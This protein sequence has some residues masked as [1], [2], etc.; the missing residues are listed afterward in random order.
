MTTTT[1]TDM[2]TLLSDVRNF[3]EER[4]IP[5]EPKLRTD[6]LAAISSGIES[7]REVAKE[8]GW[9]CPQMNAEHG[10]MGLSLHDFG[11]LSEVLGRSPLGHLA[12]NCQAPDAGNMEILADHASEAQ[13]DAFLDPLTAGEVRS[14]FAMTE[15]E[16]AGSNPKQ[17][18]TTAE[19]VSDENGEAYVLNGHKWFTTGADGADFTIVM[20]VTNPDA[21]NP[22]QRA[23]MIIVPMDAEGLEHVRKIPIMGE[24]GEGWLS[25]SELR[26]HDVRVPVDNRLGPEKH[27]FTI[28]Q[29]RLGPGRIHH[30]MRWIGIC[31]RAFEM[32]C[33]R[34]ASRELSPGTPLAS[35]QTI[36][37]WVAESRARI[38]AARLMVLKAARTIDEKGARAAR[39]DISTIKYF[40]ADTLH[41]VLDQAIQVHGALG[42]TDD[43]L[44]SFWYRHER[45]ASIYDGPSE[46]HKSV[47]ARRVFR[48]YGVNL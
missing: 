21:D 34:A 30:C 28:A 35:K 11:R 1:A 40:V 47:V 16:N 24:E 37:N 22:Y 7:A 46:V 18:S 12:L 45:G 15:P 8:N 42:V 5:L 19:R 6:G 41:E 44:L 9:W 3:V 33:E 4:L 13:K 32:M 10:G 25:H 36:Q 43:T 29:E 39:V 48:E 31:E 38:D 26:F 2:D 23:S 17:L 20:A 27:G 14:C